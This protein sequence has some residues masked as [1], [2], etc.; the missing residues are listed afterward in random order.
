[1]SDKS[2]STDIISFKACFEV[3][4]RLARRTFLALICVKKNA[5][6][7]ND[8]FLIWLKEPEAVGPYG[9]LSESKNLFAFF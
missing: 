7:E 1:M 6:R 3:E 4:E 9:E 5:D 2:K 8:V